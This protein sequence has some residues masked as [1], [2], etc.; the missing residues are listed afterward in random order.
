MNNDS[1]QL[2]IP[3]KPDY[4]SLVR[5]TASSIGHKCGLNIDEIEDIKVSIAEAC[6]N[7]L[8][9]TEKETIFIDFNIDEDRLLIKVSDTKKNIPEGLEEAKDRELGILI[10]TSLMDEVEFN[11][12]GI[13]MTK[14]F[15]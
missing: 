6:I 13:E 12:I 14:Y 10:I 15:E 3:S 7:S 11:D 8:S 9:L 2:K 1:V 4:I 5:L